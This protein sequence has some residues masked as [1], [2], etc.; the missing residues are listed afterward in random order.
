MLFFV[1]WLK[2]WLF[3]FCAFLFVLCFTFGIYLITGGN[4]KQQYI[5]LQKKDIEWEIKR[6][7]LR[8]MLNAFKK[9]E[10]K[11]RLQLSEKPNDAETEY[12]LM[13]L[14]AIKALQ[15]GNIER[16]KVLWQQALNKIPNTK[17]NQNMRIRIENSLKNL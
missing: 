1:P 2:S 16:A 11:L 17:D 5:S 15:Q 6:N 4:Q 9:Q 7:D 14:M 3:R 8:Q 10:F 12:K 13:D